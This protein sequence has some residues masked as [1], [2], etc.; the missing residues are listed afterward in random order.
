MWYRVLHYRVSEG[1]TAIFRERCTLLK[2]KITLIRLNQNLSF[3]N[4]LECIK[5]LIKKF[6]NL[7]KMSNFN[8]KK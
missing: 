4:C 3:S 7:G 5:D 6:A 8:I 2:N 1:I